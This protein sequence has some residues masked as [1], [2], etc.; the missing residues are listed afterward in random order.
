MVASWVDGSTAVT[1]VEINSYVGSQNQFLSLKAGSTRMRVESING[2]MARCS[3]PLSLDS[4]DRYAAMFPIEDLEPA[5]DWI[6][7]VRGWVELEPA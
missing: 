7:T 1:S 4:K 2:D 5:R 6:F 3:Y